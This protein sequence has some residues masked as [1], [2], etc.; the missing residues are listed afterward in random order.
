[1]ASRLAHIAQPHQVRQQSVGRAARNAQPIGHGTQLQALAVL[2]QQF[3]DG[4]GS[5]KYA[6]H[7]RHGSSI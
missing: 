7:T 2:R 5:F 4:Q 3:E 1:M 6:I